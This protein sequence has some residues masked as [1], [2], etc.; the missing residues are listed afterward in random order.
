MGSDLGEAIIKML[1]WLAYRTLGVF[2]AGIFAGWIIW[3]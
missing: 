3:G 1:F 2:L